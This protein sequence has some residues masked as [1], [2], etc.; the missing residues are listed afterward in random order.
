[1]RKFFVYTFLVALVAIAG[2]AFPS[3]NAQARP[4]HWE[5]PPG[6]IRHDV[7]GV[8]G[9]DWWCTEPTPEPTEEPKPEETPTQEP[10]VTKTPEAPRATEEPK[11]P[12]WSDCDAKIDDVHPGMLDEWKSRC[13]PEDVKSTPVPVSICIECGDRP[14]KDEVLVE[15]ARTN[16]A[17]GMGMTAQV[18][19]FECD[20][21]RL[22]VLTEQFTV[23]YGYRANEVLQPQEFKNKEGTY[24]VYFGEWLYETYYITMVDGSIENMITLHRAGV[25][26]YGPCVLTPDDANPWQW[27]GTTFML[28]PGQSPDEVSAHIAALGVTLDKTVA[29]MFTAYRA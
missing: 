17:I 10:P 7:E 29:E 18:C 8:Y 22:I 5:C 21:Q 28:F 1:M 13:M 12:H 9:V 19:N 16:G 26:D 15:Y 11:G 20:E 6:Q 24:Y 4:L 14:H 23:H 2:L 25:I 27:D 3:G